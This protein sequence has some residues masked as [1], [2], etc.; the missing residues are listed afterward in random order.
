MSKPATRPASPVNKDLTAVKPE[1]RQI[2]SKFMQCHLNQ[3][4]VGEPELSRDYSY[5]AS[6]AKRPRPLLSGKHVNVPRSEAKLNRSEL[7]L[8]FQTPVR[9]Q[10]E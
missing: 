9:V 10:R 7:K 6:G 5:M 4:V 3:V 1:R 8:N 2:K